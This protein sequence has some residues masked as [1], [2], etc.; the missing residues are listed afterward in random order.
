V[1]PHWRRPILRIIVA[2]YLVGMGFVLGVIVERWRFDGVR[3]QV[4]DRYNEVMRQVR[5]HQMKI[6]LEG[7]R[8]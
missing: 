3:Q 6:E 7:E 8:K 1:S 2:L 4:L 5:S